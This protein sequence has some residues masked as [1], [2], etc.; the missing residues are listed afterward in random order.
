MAGE[1]IPIGARIIS[2]V[3]C[4][5]ALT[6]DRPYRVA[7]TDEAALA[8]VRERSGHMYDPKVVGALT[9]L[10]ESVRASLAPAP[11]P[12]VSA[13][14]ARANVRPS[15]AVGQAADTSSLPSPPP[16]ANRT[17]KAQWATL[18]RLWPLLKA[19]PSRA[20]DNAEVAFALIST[21]LRAMTGAATVTV[22]VTDIAA[23][24]VAV[25]HA[26]GHAEHLL[27]QRQVRLGEG[28]TGWVA[29]HQQPILNSDPL[30]DFP[31]QFRALEPKL[32]AALSVPIGS[33][34]ALTL[35]TDAPSGFDPA[36]RGVADEAA[37]RL[38]GWVS[39]PIAPNGTPE[40]P[41]TTVADH[42]LE[43]LLL[44]SAAGRS[45]GVLS[46]TF[47]AGTAG[48][49]FDETALAAVVLPA[50]RLSDSLFVASA[51]EIVAVLPGCEPDA[52]A[53][54]HDRL[55]L[56]LTETASPFAISVGFGVTPRDGLSLDDALRVA[57]DNRRI[58]SRG[59]RCGCEEVAAVH[60][61]RGAAS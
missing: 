24:S 6:S 55:T 42:R 19:D 22:G 59:H 14:I 1:D 11:E 7:L 21:W 3:D 8:I 34:G 31:G 2:V 30:L 16:T 38:L 48:E 52:E 47:A 35:Y 26:S 49:P 57:Q 61:A 5:D 12:E 39:R 13:L 4:F 50:L 45:L 17:M 54:M 46:V 29:A 23:Q 53:L 25:V 18:D 36:D 28:I 27:R 32:T 41:E 9:A 40:T 20:S 44:T 33:V 10:Y 58:V 43:T 56:V 51:T 15:N 60:V 37:R